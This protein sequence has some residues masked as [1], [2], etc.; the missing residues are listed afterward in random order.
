MDSVIKLI[1]V[2]RREK[3]RIYA[4]VAPAMIHK[5]HP[6]ANVEDVFNAIVVRGDAIG[7]AMFYG[8]GAG[9]LPTA[10]AVVADIIDI[11]RHIDSGARNIWIRKN[12]NNIV[13]IEESKTRL[14][15]RAAV[16]N[17]GEASKYIDKTF[18]KVE[19]IDSGKKELA[20]ELAFTTQKKTEAE[21]N[22]CIDALKGVGSVRE[23]LNVIRI[24][25]D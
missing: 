16:R 8:R 22:S 11:A 13:P 18:G 15:I 9:K 7:D 17:R 4:R 19:Y 6:L 10:S 20:N 1:A 12:V 2:S 23:V 5:D 24:E 25:E 14:F 21:L 3:G